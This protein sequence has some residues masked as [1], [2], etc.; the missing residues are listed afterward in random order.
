MGI[1]A[2]LLAEIKHETHNTRRVLDNLN[3]EHWDYK[4]HEKSMTLGQLAS[5]IVELHNW[6]HLAVTKD[7]FDFHTDYTPPKTADVETLKTELESGL[8]KNNEFINSKTDDFWLTN[9]I[10]KA[11][12]HTLSEMP[13][14]GAFRYIITNHLI[15][16]RGQLTVY[17]RMLNIPLPGIY[18]PSADEK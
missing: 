3:D 2:G 1:K 8:Q 16:H 17:M 14:L 15:H 4:P 10:L 12:T 13:K 6:T 5:H 18:G 9:W 11:G 7:V